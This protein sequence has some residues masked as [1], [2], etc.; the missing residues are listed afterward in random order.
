MMAPEQLPP[1]TDFPAILGGHEAGD[2]HEHGQQF[3]Q[4]GQQEAATNANDAESA[5]KRGLSEITVDEAPGVKEEEQLFGRATEA[6]PRKRRRYRNISDWPIGFREELQAWRRLPNED[7]QR[8]QF[9]A[10]PEE[11]QYLAIYSTTPTRRVTLRAWKARRP[12]QPAAPQ[13]GHQFTAPNDVI[14]LPPP[15]ITFPG[16]GG[17]ARTHADNTAHHTHHSTP[18]THHG[19]PH[20]RATAEA[21]RAEEEASVGGTEKGSGI[22]VT[23]VPGEGEDV[24][25]PQ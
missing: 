15:P 16:F 7:L 25:T 8:T 21:N 17:E 24:P 10:W 14:C 1:P 3:M 20:T 23:Q 4:I 6:A 12:A 18:H 13:P 11:Y 9:Q 5:P 19:T 2:P 22:D